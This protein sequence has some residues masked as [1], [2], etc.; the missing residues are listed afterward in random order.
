MDRLEYVV[1][2]LQMEYGAIRQEMRDFNS[3]MMKNL[4][5]AIT[6]TSGLVAVAGATHNITICYIIPTAIFFF[7]MIHLILTSNKSILGAYCLVIQE[8]LKEE[9]GAKNVVL[10]WESGS[11]WAR[12]AL[13]FSIVQNGFYL[14]YVPVLVS[15]LCLTWEAYRWHKWTAIPHIGLLL[16]ATAYGIACALWNT[17]GRREST[18]RL[19]R[20]RLSCCMT[21]DRP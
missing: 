20:H 18:L 15:F 3:S 7:F 10:E 16:I 14:L 19:N 9:L 8:K 2:T 21:T 5:T 11:L 17:H 13:P 6:V 4:A 1:S 12:T